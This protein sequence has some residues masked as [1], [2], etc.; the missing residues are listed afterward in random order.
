MTPPQ[1]TRQLRSWWWCFIVWNV[2]HYLLGL[3]ATIGT[4][5]IAKNTTVDYGNLAILVAI[6]TAAIT[7]LKSG[8]KA[9]AYLVAWRQLNAERICFELDPSYTEAKLADAHK[10]GEEVIGKAD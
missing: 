10:K 4:V 8:S 7:F 1:I 6:A 9:N 2:I 3:T 5:L